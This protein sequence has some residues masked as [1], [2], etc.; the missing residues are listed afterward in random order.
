MA[1]KTDQ[2]KLL[3]NFE[4]EFISKGP[5]EEGWIGQYYRCPICKYYVDRTKYDECDCGNISIDV[6]YCRIIVEKCEESEIKVYNV[7]KKIKNR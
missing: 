5:T 6:D 3:E 7:K 2:N 1:E 4:L